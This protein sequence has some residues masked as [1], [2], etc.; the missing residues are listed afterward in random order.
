[1]YK[2]EA[3]LEKKVW[4]QKT[5]ENNN[6]RQKKLQELERNICIDSILIE[7]T[8]TALPLPLANLSCSFSNNFLLASK[9]ILAF[10]S[11]KLLS[12]FSELVSQTT[13]FAFAL[14]LSLPS[15][16]D[17]LPEDDNV[18]GSIKSFRLSNPN[19]VISEIG[20]FDCDEFDC[21]A[22]TTTGVGAGTSSGKNPAG[23]Y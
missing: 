19:F 12:L 11:F 4:V 20:G 21:E 2:K 16:S 6:K 17:S 13:A 10:L 14:P 3:A 8:Q 9:T 1:M 15:P 23:G 7:I 18:V 5:C 22:I